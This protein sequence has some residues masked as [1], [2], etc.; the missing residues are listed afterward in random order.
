MHRKFLCLFSFF[1]LS[2]SL[3]CQLFPKRHFHTEDG[4]IQKQITTLFEDSRGALWIGTKGGV[5]RFDGHNM[6]SW[7]VQNG[8]AGN[9]IKAFSEDSAG[10]ILVYTKDGV[11]R[12]YGKKV[13]G[14]TS[15][16]APAPA[17]EK[18]GQKVCSV[19][20]QIAG[21]FWYDEKDTHNL[22][23]R[24]D[25]T[26]VAIN[27]PFGS[28]TWLMLDKRMQI[29]VGNIACAIQQRLRSI[30]AARF[31]NRDCRARVLPHKIFSKCL[32]NGTDCRRAI[33][34]QFLSLCAQA[35]RHQ[36]NSYQHELVHTCFPFIS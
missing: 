3:F 36:S 33:Q 1:I 18:T 29:W 17:H 10:G 31:T 6:V 2:N 14:I 26:D 19:I 11:S 30:P 9:W 15:K 13:I 21:K 28:I 34:R 24:H 7:S 12:I 16:N 4:L 27:Y 5:T 23:L 8:L 22:W 25:S 20:H 35:P 32:C